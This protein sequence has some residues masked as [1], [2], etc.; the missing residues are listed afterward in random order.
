MLWLLV[1]LRMTYRG[2]SYS[3]LQWNSAARPSD[4][5]GM[6]PWRVRIGGGTAIVGVDMVYII[7]VLLRFSSVTVHN[8]GGR[9]Y[10]VVRF[11]A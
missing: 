1:K 7:E 11:F 3:Y 6:L 4:R 8:R 9:C 5:F 10:P 2:A